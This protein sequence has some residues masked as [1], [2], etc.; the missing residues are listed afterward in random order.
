VE[1]VVLATDAPGTEG[2][3]GRYERSAAKSFDE[4]DRSCQV[5]LQEIILPDE[6]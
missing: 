1:T 6:P 4:D 3:D 5:G 2:S